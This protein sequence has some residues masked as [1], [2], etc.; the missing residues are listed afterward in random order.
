MIKQRHIVVTDEKK[1]EKERK[2]R[3][4]DI[5]TGCHGIQSLFQTTVDVSSFESIIKV[6]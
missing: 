3:E 1:R 4:V 2:S 5:E 6:G